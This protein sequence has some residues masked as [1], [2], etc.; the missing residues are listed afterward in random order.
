M[1]SVG[2]VPSQPAHKVGQDSVAVLQ[3]LGYS[4]EEIDAMIESGAIAIKRKV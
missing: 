1:E 3:E 2:K 4:Q